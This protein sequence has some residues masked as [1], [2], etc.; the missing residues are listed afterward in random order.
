LEFG[1]ALSELTSNIRSFPNVDFETI[2]ILR[3][4]QELW[5]TVKT[6]GKSELHDLV[7]VDK[8]VVRNVLV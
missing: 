3:D 1:K 2:F 4:G 8:M 6:T 7:V 5:K